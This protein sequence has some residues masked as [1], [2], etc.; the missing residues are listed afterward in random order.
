VIELASWTAGG[1]S[2]RGSRHERDGKPNQDAIAV[3]Q[4]PVALIA[5]ADGHGSPRCTRSD[6]G[7]AFAVA[8]ARD[9]VPAFAGDARE[10][11]ALRADLAERVVATWRARVTAHLA[12]HPL[13]AD[14]AAL[15][16][17]PPVRAYGATLVAAMAH[18]DTLIALQIG[19]GDAWIADANAARRLVPRDL[20]FALNGTA[21][22][23]M[24][25]ATAEVRVARV[26]V[27][28]AALAIVATDGYARPIATDDAFARAQHALFERVSTLGLAA[29]LDALP[30]DLA[31]ASAHGGDDV[32]VGMV[33]RA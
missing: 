16:D 23:C 31:G 18:G 3:V 26:T 21:S 1:R 30:V 19:D 14:E 5:V 24:D 17:A 10:L 27:E 33:Y 22:L 13:D 7:A 29:V 25:D 28:R 9:V 4:S 6:V 2:A 20:R 12:A 32:T 11:A 8:V 15:V